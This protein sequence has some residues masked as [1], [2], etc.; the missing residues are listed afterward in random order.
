MKKESI[1]NLRRALNEGFTNP[2]KIAS[3]GSFL[4]LRDLPEFQ[5]LIAAQGTSQ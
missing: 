2:K 5:Q 4:A 1:Q 3:D